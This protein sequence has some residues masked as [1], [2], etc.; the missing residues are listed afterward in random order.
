M[1]K[2]VISGKCPKCQEMMYTQLVDPVL[3]QWFEDLQARQPE[4]HL[5]YTYRGKAEQDKLYREKKSNAKFGQSPHNYQPVLAFDIFFLVNGKYYLDMAWLQ[6]IANNMP[7]EME[8]GG[9]WKTLK[10]GP[11]FQRKDWKK[12]A[13][14]YPNGD[15]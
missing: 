15:K 1:A 13:K 10:D 14:N 4:V 6:A 8:W 2:H 12:H 11:H 9:N 5:A 3:R 7:A